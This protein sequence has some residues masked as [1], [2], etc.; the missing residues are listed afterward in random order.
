MSAKICTCADLVNNGDYY[1]PIHGIFATKVC[2][3]CRCEITSWLTSAGHHYWSHVLNCQNLD[4][5]PEPADDT[6]GERGFDVTAA[7]KNMF[8]LNKAAEIV[9]GEPAPSADGRR[10][11]LANRIVA[12]VFPS[13]DRECAARYIEQ[14]ERILAAPAPVS[15]ERRE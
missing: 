7:A 12:E 13:M 4:H 9:L 5:I 11:E 15:G 3:K 6:G 2:K 1:C 8:N 14:I 10:R